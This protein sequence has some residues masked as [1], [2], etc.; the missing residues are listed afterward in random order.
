M[1]YSE[2]T[3]VTRTGTDAK[4]DSVIPGEQ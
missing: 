2:W 4:G 1:I 3:W